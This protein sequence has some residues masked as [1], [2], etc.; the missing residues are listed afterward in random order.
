MQVSDSVEPFLSRLH[1]YVIN[2]LN[3]HVIDFDSFADQSVPK[4]KIQ[5]E[6]QQIG[7]RLRYKW[8]CDNP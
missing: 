5:C 3:F 8:I 4:C 7:I 6:M 2:N 1:Q